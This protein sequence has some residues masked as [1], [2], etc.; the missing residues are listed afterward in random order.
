MCE[1]KFSVFLSP[2]CLTELS[3]I[4]AMEIYRQ[5]RGIL[6]IRSMQIELCHFIDCFRQINRR[7]SKNA[8]E[9]G[10]GVDL[11]LGDWSHAGGSWSWKI[12]QYLTFSHWIQVNRRN[13]LE[14]L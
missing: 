11:S 9:C 6:I 5:M 3:L 8:T 10:L 13:N 1:Y 2:F 14:A 4:P 7:Q 12:I